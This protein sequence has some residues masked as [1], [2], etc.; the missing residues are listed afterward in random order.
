MTLFSIFMGKPFGPGDEVVPGYQL[1]ELLGRGGFGE[2]WRATGPGGIPCALK[3]VSIHGK[4]G[5]KEALALELVKE[6][7]HPNLVPIFGSWV[8]DGLRRQVDLDFFKVQETVVTPDVERHLRA[9][10]AS[11]GSE[12]RDAGVLV[13]AMGLGEKSLYDRLEECQQSG[14]TGVPVDELLD[15]MDG[16]ARAIDYLNQPKH[17]LGSGPVSIQHCDIKPQ[18]ILIVGGAAQVCDYG[19]ARALDDVRK[20]ASVTPAYGAPE[21]LRGDTSRTTDQY[22]LAIAYTELRTG[23]LPFA[24][25]SL[26]GILEAK[27]TGNLDLSGLSPAEQLVIRRATDIDPARRFES[28]GQMARALHEA[29]KTGTVSEES[30]PI[31][32]PPTRGVAKGWRA[33]GATAAALALVGLVGYW[34]IEANRNAVAD[35]STVDET[36]ADPVALASQRL[37]A[38]A[39]LVDKNPQQ[40]ADELEV[41]AQLLRNSGGDEARGVR[42][43]A[44]VERAHALSLLSNIPWPEVVQCLQEAESL[45][46]L[47]SWQ[48]QQR[49]THAALTAA[50]AVPLQPR[51]ADLQRQALQMALQ[52]ADGWR[53][54][55]PASGQV[56][57]PRCAALGRHLRQ[58]AEQLIVAHGS[59]SHEQK[60]RDCDL[61]LELFPGEAEFLQAKLAT[62]Q[63]QQDQVAVA[64]VERAL[65]DQEDRQQSQTW[66]E[67][68]ERT[69]AET[70]ASADK[71]QE[72]LASAPAWLTANDEGLKAERLSAYGQ[73]A[74]G[75]EAQPKLFAASWP[76][77][78]S[79]PEDV[80]N[81]DG[82]RLALEKVFARELEQQVLGPSRE[83]DFGGLL[84]LARGAMS[85]GATVE[86]ANFALAEGLMETTPRESLTRELWSEA[87]RACG[88]PHLASHEASGP[89]LDYGLYVQALVLERAGDTVDGETVDWE[90]VGQRL[91]ALTPSLSES[92]PNWIRGVRAERLAE[93]LDAAALAE[94]SWEDSL[95][96]R[97]GCPFGAE[98]TLSAERAGRAAERLK[99]A[100]SLTPMRAARD[101]RAP[102]AELLAAWYRQ[103]PDL[104]TAAGRADELCHSEQTDLAVWLAGARV[105]SEQEATRNAA[106]LRYA[107]GAELLTQQA[108][109]ERISEPLECDAAL[110][111]PGLKL[112]AA[113][114]LEK[115]TGSEQSVDEQR[116]A[117]AQLYALRARLLAESPDEAWPGLENDSRAIQQARWEAIDRAVRLDPTRAAYW[118]ARG[119]AAARLNTMSGGEL[120]SADWQQV[121]DDAEQA[122]KLEPGLARSAALLGLARVNQARQ[123]RGGSAEVEQHLEQAIAAYDRALADTAGG[124]GSGVRPGDRAAY[125]VGRAT[126][127]VE[128]GSARDYAAQREALR[129][130]LSAAQRDAQAAIEITPRDNPQF[131]WEVLGNAAEDLAW[132]GGQSAAEQYS[133]AIGAFDRAIEM[134]MDTPAVWLHRGRCRLKWLS[135]S[136]ETVEKREEFLQQGRNDLEQA[137]RKSS[138]ASASQQ[139]D[140]L[141][142]LGRS[143]RAANDFATSAAAQAEA[144]QVQSE[145]VALLIA[146]ERP[147]HGDWFWQQKEWAALAL[148]EG[149]ADVAL[150]RVQELLRQADRTDLDLE[151]SPRVRMGAV[152]VAVEALKAQKQAAEGLAFCQRELPADWAD[153]E[154][155][156]LPLMLAG[157]ELLLDHNELWKADQDRAAEAQWF[158]AAMQ[159]A[160]Q[161]VADAEGDPWQ[162]RVALLSGEGALRTFSQNQSTEECHAA[163]GYFEQVLTLPHEASDGRMA[164]FWLAQLIS[165]AEAYLGKP[166][167]FAGVADLAAK[168]QYLER[169]LSV[170]NEDPEVAQLVGRERVRRLKQTLE[171]QVKRLAEAPPKP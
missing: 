146:A 126:A 80:R 83:I 81:D 34:W 155:A 142:W 91:D 94:L 137:R 14:L 157:G 88:L 156:H 161:I 3:I 145:A 20:T 48:P 75:I 152:L 38:A 57:D 170:L 171:A 58:A 121:A 35:A 77:L 116:V 64:E 147:L 87:A 103:P 159:R 168:R 67:G 138:E 17:D 90:G 167:P 5:R 95:A 122:L 32:L 47:E 19:L 52:L 98:P 25:E 120:A 112:V 62:V 11:G 163:I 133:Q 54:G 13:I 89:W 166:G 135:Q 76:L 106:L 153:C 149:K 21:T 28:C 93:V 158:A 69:L 127:R 46:P 15:Y 56:V 134:G 111:D 162:S 53:E 110:V 105:A 1:V 114:G 160:R 115:A 92:R 33:I 22:S 44:L 129:E 164:R 12:R 55:K 10:I 141:Y 40:A 85:L 84:E 2:V 97:L 7:H 63:A 4:Q 23:R 169:G 42:R 18:N 50:S 30:L 108:G 16:S 29:V 59:E 143:Y 113:L 43:E 78:R 37:A 128:L 51:Q 123:R 31:P 8:I 73:V 39:A 41:V 101:P 125:L 60:R 119:E 140:I 49:R 124:D 136:P 27:E 9:T 150:A 71:L 154:L 130:L 74:Q 104:E 144:E 99:L 6:I 72:Y 82:L 24:D 109:F 66:L 45:L 139:A 70:D 107:K 86:G 61:V 117:A 118:T 26:R 132:L 165:Q 65:R 102:A 68:L 96:G 131:A 79:V 151:V 148:E 36:G 100:E